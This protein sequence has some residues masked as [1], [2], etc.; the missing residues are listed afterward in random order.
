MSRSIEYH[1]LEKSFKAPKN[2]YEP[3]TRVPRKFKKKWKHILASERYKH[4]DLGQKLWFINYLS[5]PDYNRFLIMDICL[6]I[7]PKKDGT[8]I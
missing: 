4:L 3:K 1:K 7:K 8:Y 6:K 5:N 2:F